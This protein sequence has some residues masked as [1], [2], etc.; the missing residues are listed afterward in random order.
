MVKKDLR[1]H[2]VQLYKTSAKKSLWKWEKGPT[3]GFKNPYDGKSLATRLKNMQQPRRNY[4]TYFRTT[5]SFKLNNKRFDFLL[6]QYAICK[7][8]QQFNYVVSTNEKIAQNGPDIF[9]NFS[10]N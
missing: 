3:L 6:S 8:S 7:D 4:P 5:T 2:L 1:S 9:C 10:K